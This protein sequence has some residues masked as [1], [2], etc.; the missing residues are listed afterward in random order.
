MKLQQRVA[1][2]SSIKAEIINLEVSG[3]HR[4]VKE[5]LHP[6]PQFFSLT[7]WGSKLDYY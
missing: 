3:C 2:S 1:L 7:S 4:Y 6:K 5:C